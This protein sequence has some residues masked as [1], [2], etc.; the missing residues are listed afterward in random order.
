[1]VSKIA[2]AEFTG[3]V[4]SYNFVVYP[5]GTDFKAVRAVYVITKRTA[6]IY[7]RGTHSFI[8]IGQTGD[9]SE[10]FDNHD[11][12]DCFTKRGANC[13]CI[14]EESDEQKRLAIESD[15]LDGNDTACNG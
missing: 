2:D 10:R 1:L 3:K 9:L 14:H 12:A 4:G 6:D 7:S 5:W 8:Y 11:K 15:L 13:I